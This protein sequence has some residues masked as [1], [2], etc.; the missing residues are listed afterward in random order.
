MDRKDPLTVKSF[1]M[2]QDKAAA[3]IVLDCGVPFVQYPYVGV[4]SSFY[5]TVPEMEEYL[6]GHNDI[7]E[8]LLEIF[9]DYKHDH[10][11]WSKVLWDMTAIT[12]LINSD[13]RPTYLVHAPR[14]SELD[15]DSF[16]NNRHLIRMVYGINRDPILLDFLQRFRGLA[17]E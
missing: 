16:N 1:N 7:S 17:S 15:T 9:K 6:K 10:F 8:Y 12:Y 2:F 4:V 13:W 5:T 3:N 14:V 11:G